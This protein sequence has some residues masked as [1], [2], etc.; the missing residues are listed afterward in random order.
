MFGQ[1]IMMGSYLLS[2]TIKENHPKKAKAI[3]FAGHIVGAAGL[4]YK[5]TQATSGYTQR[6]K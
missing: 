6:L 3:R 1:G 4:F 2:E 5:G